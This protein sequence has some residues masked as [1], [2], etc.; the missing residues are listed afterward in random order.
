MV[1]PGDFVVVELP[2]K[3]APWRSSGATALAALDRAL[4]LDSGK[5]VGLIV[6]SGLEGAL[7]IGAVTQTLVAAWKSDFKAG[8]VVVS[9][10]PTHGGAHRPVS[11]IDLK[12]HPISDPISLARS[13][14]L[15]ASLGVCF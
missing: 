12:A 8:S 11:A 13:L 10:R 3:R 14:M 4:A 2:G 6:G 7:D 1:A 9:G 15:S 5:P